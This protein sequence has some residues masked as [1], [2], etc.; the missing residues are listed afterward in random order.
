MNAEA[1]HIAP[2][3]IRKSL[4]IKASRQKAFDTFVRG[5]SGWW[6]KGHSLLASPQKDVLIEPRA[7]GRWYETGEDGSEMI[8]GKVMEWDEPDR[9]VLAWQLNADFKYDPD[10][11][12][13][14]EVRFVAEGEGRTRVEFEHRNLERFGERAEQVRTALDSEGGWTGM[15]ETYAKAAAA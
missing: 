12:T 10:L 14:V 7:G 1:Q 6:L 5:M 11:T 13:E 2:A 3:P 4:R 15:L 9:V 8:W